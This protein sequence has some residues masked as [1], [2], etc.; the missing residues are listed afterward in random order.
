MSAPTGDQAGGFSTGASQV[1]TDPT[2]GAS[3]GRSVGDIVGD[4]ARDLSTLVRQELDL[5]KTEAKQQAAKAG[6]G[7]GLLGGAGVAALLMLI[8]VS[9]ALTYLLDNVMPVELAALLVG[10]ILAVAAAVLGLAGKKRLQQTEPQLPTTQRTLK[11]DAQWAKAQKN[12]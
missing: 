11:E 9:L 8:F 2:A 1:D 7:A 12:S 6:K 3:A 5:A 10:L 4:I